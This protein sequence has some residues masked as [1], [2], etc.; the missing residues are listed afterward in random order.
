MDFL[1]L[2]LENIDGEAAEVVADVFNR[3]GY[4]GAVMESAPPDF[5]RVTVRTVI[6]A[7]DEDTR[8]KIEI[9]I[10]LIG[11]ALPQKLPELQTEFVGEN[12]WAESWKENFHVVHIGRVVIQPSWREYSP[13]PDEIVVHLD[14]GV[15]FGSGL[16]PTTSLCLKILQEMPLAGVDMFD[17]GTGSGILS[18]AAAKMGASPIRAVDVDA[19]AVRVA[20][21][22]FALNGVSPIET[23]VGS[24]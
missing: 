9:A 22:N 10:A 5:E 19:V 2:S 24:A 3:Y 17:V 11:Q 7:T 13:A 6:P 4:G 23:A 8:Q 21:E 14:P 16:H 18:V 15:A 20:E 12:D 1:K